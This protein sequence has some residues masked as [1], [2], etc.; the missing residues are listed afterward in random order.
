M[1][2]PDFNL[3]ENLTMHGGN[4][5]QTILLSS[6]ALQ[7]FATFEACLDAWLAAEDAS[8][9]DFHNIFFNSIFSLPLPEF[10]AGRLFI[11][12]AETAFAQRILHD[13]E[14]HRTDQLEEACLSMLEDIP[15]WHMRSRRRSLLQQLERLQGDDDPAPRPLKPQSQQRPARLHPVVS[16]YEQMQK[17][18]WQRRQWRMLHRPQRLLTPVQGP[19]YV[20]HLY[21]GRRREH[22]FHAHMTSI[23]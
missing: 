2:Y 11:L 9:A 14:L 4:L 19:Y 20:I 15:I 1:S 13:D 21:S 10:Q 5:Q 16:R 6:S 23:A 3:K 17:E 8:T 12:W 7:H 18:E 22:D